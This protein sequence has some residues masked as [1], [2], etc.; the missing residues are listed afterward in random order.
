NALP[1]LGKTG[2]MSIHERGALGNG[3][4]IAICDLGFFKV[5]PDIMRGTQNLSDKYSDSYTYAWGALGLGNNVLPMQIFGRGSDFKEP[6]RLPYHGSEMLSYA[7]TMAPEAQIL[8]VAV[9]DSAESWIECLTSLSNNPEVDII[10]M[11][12]GL[13]GAGSL[14]SD[15]FHMI[16]PGLKKALHQ[17]L[18][19]GKIVILG[20]GNDGA[21]IPDM[22]ETPD[23]SDVRAEL[24][25]TTALISR[26]LQAESV[27]F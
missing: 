14:G 10:N 6:V 11:S 26:R 21:I 7:Q 18:A 2:V 23:Y 9:D 12:R 3:K 19:K 17:C 13:A 16:H 15:T 22:P 20:A 24:F 8:P 25:D 4:R 27:A 1:I 5:I